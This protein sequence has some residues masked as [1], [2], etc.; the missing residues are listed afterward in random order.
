MHESVYIQHKTVLAR[1]TSAELHCAFSYA[2]IW[3]IK[4][5]ES[6]NVSTRKD[7]TG[8]RFGRWTVIGYSHT[9]RNRNANWFC[10]CDCGE[11]KTVMGQN[12]RN[13][14]SKSCGC[15]MMDRITTHG[16]FGTR[17]YHIWD[18]MI[19]RCNNRDSKAYEGYGQRG[20]GICTEWLRFENFYAWAIDNG[21]SN[22]LTIDRT[23][24]DG[25]YKPNN[26]KWVDRVAQ[27]NNRRSNVMITYKG[28][29]QTLAQ[30]IRELKLS[31]NVRLRIYN[32][33]NVARAFEEPVMARI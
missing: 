22:K 24:N 15:F 5:R 4:H 32:G 29:E 23:D 30:W 8:N 1:P 20:I 11:T 16:Q 31:K 25:S 27:Q 13:G 17:L 9:D 7:L 6:V 21:Y 10:K 19:Q 14:R 33:W 18:G 2:Q 3:R 26:C 28:R 12:L